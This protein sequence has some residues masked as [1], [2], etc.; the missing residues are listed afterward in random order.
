MRS[1]KYAL[2]LVLFVLLAASARAEEGEK[3][4]KKAHESWTGTLDEAPKDAKA[5]V[6]AVLKVKKD[7]KEIVVNLW[8]E[9]K[10]ADTLKEWAPKKAEVTVTGHKV[11]DTNVKVNKVEKKG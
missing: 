6:V 8:A 3:H 9:G 11:D 2:P 1:L 10:N 5:G 4:E 7:D